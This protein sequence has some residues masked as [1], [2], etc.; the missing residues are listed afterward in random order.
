M[1]VR[2]APA[3]SLK[4][5]FHWK[6]GWRWL[7]NAD[8]INTKNMKC[9]WPMPAPRVGD[10]TPS[11]V[12]LLASGVGVG[13]NTNFSVCIWGNTD[14]SVSRYQHV[15]IPNAKL[16]RWGSKPT[17]GPNAN[18]FASQRNVGL[19]LTHLVQ[20]RSVYNIILRLNILIV[21]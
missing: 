5:I 10:P 4:P 12:H 15:G 14:F 2:K 7:P 3:I 9:T 13:G 1:R 16:W 21:G 20:P 17:Q 19:I 8:E 18:G 11:I 6:L